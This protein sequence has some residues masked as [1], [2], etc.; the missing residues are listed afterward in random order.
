MIFYKRN[1]QNYKPCLIVNKLNIIKIMIKI[2][3]LWSRLVRFSILFNI[4]KKILNN[5]KNIL[6][7]N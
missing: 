4:M 1:S 7:I 3:Q 2:K 6:A 5:F